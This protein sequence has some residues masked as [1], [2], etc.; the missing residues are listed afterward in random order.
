MQAGLELPYNLCQHEFVVKMT[1]LFEDF[2]FIMYFI[3]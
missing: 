1:N 3:T 2:A